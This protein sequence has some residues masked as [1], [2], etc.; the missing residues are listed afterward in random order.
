M[1][2]DSQ[3]TKIGTL[4]VALLA[5][6]LFTFGAMAQIA[7]SANDNK[8]VLVNGVNSVPANPAADTVTIIDLG[9]SP[10]KVIGELQVPNSVVGPPQ[11][12]AITPDESL[13]LVASNQKLDTAD[14]K[15]LV[16]DYRLSVIDLKASPPAVI[17]TVGTGLGPAGIGINRAGTLAL[18]A[19]RNDGTVSVFSIAGKTVT[20]VGKVDFGNEKAGP[21][22]AAFS[23]DGKMALVTR[24]GD[25]KIS[26][27]AV[28]G[29]NVTDT[30]KYMVGAIRPY[31]I[32]FTPKGDAAIVGFQGGGTGDIDTISVIDVK[33]KAPHIVHTLDVGQIVEGLAIS[34][35]GKY[36]ALTAQN[37]SNKTPDFP[38]YN[39]HGLVVVFRIDGTNLTK[40]AQAEAGVWDQGVAWSR[41]GKTL[42]VEDMAGHALDV[43][44]FDGRS[45]RQTSEIKVSGGP[46]GLR[47]AEH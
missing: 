2:M 18:V 19:N 31:A 43:L 1:F 17:A 4:A 42:L 33:G 3:I 38:F 23:P 40:V 25:H 39:A 32:Q 45:L 11:N 7:V 22:S 27:L 20:A 34:N 28:D 5:L 29:T 47:T 10:P 35:D 13:A 21:S 24:D 14:A 9:V 6:P 37:G 44:K 30:K 8:A 36:V 15:K 41:D 46:A 12:V 26:I 16:P